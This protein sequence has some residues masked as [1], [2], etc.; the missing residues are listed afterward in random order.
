MAR[1]V[2]RVA[3]RRRDLGV[4]AGRPQ[5]QRRVHR[6]VVGVDEVVRR[7]RVVRA[8]GEHVLGDGGGFHVDGEVAAL[9]RR[10][11]KRERVEGAGVEVVGEVL[12]QLAHRLGVAVVT[13]LLR[14]LA[15]QDRQRGEVG[16]LAVAGAFGRHAEQGRKRGVAVLAL[17]DRVVVRHRLAPGGRCK[18][19]VYLAGLLECLAGVVVLEAVEQEQSP[20][21]RPLCLGRARLANVVSPRLGW[22]TAALARSRART[23]D[24]RTERMRVTEAYGKIA[25]DYAA[26]RWRGRSASRA[27]RSDLERRAH[28]KKP[29]LRGGRRGR[30]R[31]PDG[32][33]LRLLLGGLGGSDGTVARDAVGAA[34]RTARRSRG[35][36]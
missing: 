4:D 13:V 36:A 8:L 21:K 26:A 23:T 25:H 34:G 16:A 6:V 15:E 30:W 35:T 14:P 28:R 5:A 24:G 1:H 10:A 11:E 7:A 3:R 19:G 32:L 29:R 31:A 27:R 12:G 22:A 9:V 18:A 20:Q 2:E 17:P 33:R